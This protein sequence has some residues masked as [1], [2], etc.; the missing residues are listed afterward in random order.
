MQRG[1]TRPRNC[2]SLS[3]WSKRKRSWTLSELA[4]HS[5]HGGER[6]GVRRSGGAANVLFGDPYDLPW[7]HADRAGLCRAVASVSDRS[8]GVS[9]CHRVIFP[10]VRSVP[11]CVWCCRRSVQKSTR[12]IFSVESVPL[13]IRNVTG[14]ISLNSSYPELTGSTRRAAACTCVGENST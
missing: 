6:Q 14:L 1:A 11:R 9:L 5:S 4:L 12:K 10:G 8:G 2:S 3:F 7:I 13:R